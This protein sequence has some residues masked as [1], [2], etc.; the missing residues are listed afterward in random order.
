MPTLRCVDHIEPREGGRFDDRFRAASID[1]LI[2]AFNRAVGS[3]AWTR[4]R[5]DYLVALR[6]ALLSSGHDCSR[7]ISNDAMS[8]DA[9]I[10]RRGPAIAPRAG[11]E[12]R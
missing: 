8:L 4:A 3:R 11:G 6:T 7:F 2:A 9:P 10:A 5:G 1:D 12:T